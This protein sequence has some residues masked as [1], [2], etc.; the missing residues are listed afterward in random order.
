[1]S[2]T[3]IDHAA[4]A[5]KA[6]RLRAEAMHAAFAALSQWVRSHLWIGSRA[7]AR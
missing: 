3:P 6:R 5:A 7:H 1:M 4:Y 2:R